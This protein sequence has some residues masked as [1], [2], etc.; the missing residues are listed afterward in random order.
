[1]SNSRLEA[2][3]WIMIYGGLLLLSL[4]WFMDRRA[5]I[6]GVSLMAGGAVVAVVG[7]LL[8]VVRSRRKS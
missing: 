8:I 1:M 5:A 7:V 6:L 4:G 3:V 2:L